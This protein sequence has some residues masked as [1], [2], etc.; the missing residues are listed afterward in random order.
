MTFM[1]AV[2]RLPMFFVFW[3]ISGWFVPSSWS[4]FGLMMV[5]GAFVILPA[6]FYFK[7]LGREECSRV[8][9]LYYS[10]S[11]VITFVLGA[12]FLGEKFDISD[13]IGSLLLLLAGFF[14]VVKLESGFFRFHTGVLWVLIACI[15]W[16][17]SDIIAKYV[18]PSFPST[19][20][21]LS[22]Q[23]LGGFFTAFLLLLFK[24]FSRNCRIQNFKWPRSSW[25]IFA[26]NMIIFQVA[27]FVFLKALSLERVA[28]T[29]VITSVQPLMVFF[30]ELIMCKFVPQIG[31]VDTSW[32]SLLPRSIA[33][34]LMIAGLCMFT[35]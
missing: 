15:I 11:P 5:C 30:L 25:L 17:T 29:I 20:S 12:I 33:F 1:A 8:M 10:L 14:S 9:L 32:R 35:L 16:P 31:K 21:L 7:A 27:Q 24:D 2:V 23:L 6:V 26:F 18:M 19:V 3:W 4:Q 34:C 28:L 13:I 22:W